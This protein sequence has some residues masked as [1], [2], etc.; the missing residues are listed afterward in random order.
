LPQIWSP[1]A[2][3]TSRPPVS[4]FHSAWVKVED[5][6]SARFSDLSWGRNGMCCVLYMI[7][8]LCPTGSLYRMSFTTGC[9]SMPSSHGWLY[10]F[11]VMPRCLSVA[12]LLKHVGSVLSMLRE[13]ITSLQ[14]CKD[15]E[16][17]CDRPSV[18]I[19][20]AGY[21][22]GKH[23][24]CLWGRQFEPQSRDF[25]IHHV[26]HASAQFIRH[27]IAA[28]SNSP[29]GLFG[30]LAMRHSPTALLHARKHAA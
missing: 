2:L 25:S 30:A 27:I 14:V 29:R 21:M 26:H 10:P 22:R 16:T 12:N 4:W 23:G 6:M 11:S 20:V 9:L 13:R 8:R 28:R 3:A 1:K 18:G 24:R 7:S 5:V 17:R 15:H 19:E